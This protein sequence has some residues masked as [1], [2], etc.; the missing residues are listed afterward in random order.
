MPESVEVSGLSGGAGLGMVDGG[1]VELGRL[2]AVVEVEV[3][4]LGKPRRLLEADRAVSP[5]VAPWNLSSWR[6]RACRSGDMGIM[7]VWISLSSVFCC[8]SGLEETVRVVET[9]SGGAGGGAVD[10]SI[11]CPSSESA[12]TPGPFSVPAHSLPLES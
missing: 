8:E 5:A 4:G 11:D 9:V 3:G 1:G 10:S 6:S 2:A 7:S 12:D